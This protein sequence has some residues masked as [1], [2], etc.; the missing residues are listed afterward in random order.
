MQL[1][2]QFVSE[3]PIIPPIGGMSTKTLKAIFITVGEKGEYK[4]E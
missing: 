4:H 3:T 1:D 2:T